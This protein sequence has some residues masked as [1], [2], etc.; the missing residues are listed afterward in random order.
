MK[1]NTNKLVSIIIPTYKGNT[2]LK[3]AINSALSQSYSNIE[4]I[5]VDDNNPD[6]QDRLETERVMGAFIDNP[7]VRYIKHEKN[8]NGSAARNT[9]VK[10]SK[11][12][13]LAFLDDDDELL[14]S[15]IESMVSRLEDLPLEWGAAYSN[16]EV[17][18]PNGQRLHYGEKKE[19]ALLKDALMRNLM[20]AAGSNL[21][22][23]KSVFN[24]L[25]GFDESFKR[26]QDLEFLVRL[27]K[28][29]KIAYVD[30]LGLIV[31]QQ[32]KIS[33]ADFKELTNKYLETFDEAIK[34]F[35]DKEQ[36]QI[37]TMLCLQVFRYDFFRK[38][39]HGAFNVIKDNKVSLLLAARYLFHLM[40]RYFTKSIKGFDL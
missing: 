11:G 37:K 27:L 30:N 21:L 8:K 34:T 40:G 13:Y 33:H 3:R 15:K 5:V 16:Y 10:N 7:M 6:T 36:C 35:P 1:R 39:I 32:I 22:V 17:I 20:I 25:N 19:G 28:E 24:E 12:E 2:F 31:H 26:N 38:K 18:R 29:Y 4:V 23:R 14:P 9:G